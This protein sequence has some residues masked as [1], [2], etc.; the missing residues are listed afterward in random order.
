MKSIEVGQDV[1][2][3]APLGS[4][5]KAIVQDVGGA[6]L[7]LELFSGMRDPMERL[8]GERVAVQF[9]SRR[10]ICRIQGDARRSRLGAT[11]MQFHAVGKSVLIQR[12]DYVRIDA[13][14]PVTYQPIGM[15]GWTVETNTLNVS[16]GGF[17]LP[18][19]EGVRLGQ[20]LRF[21][22]ELSEDDQPLEVTAKAVR[23]TAGGA[24][25]F[26]ITGI[27][28]H[29]RDRLMHWVFARERLARQI[30]RDG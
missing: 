24:L 23:E 30:T 10:G 11:A 13:V 29:E 22:I 9:A 4:P 7:D 21:T 27:D 20:E 8:D 17:L 18:E 12:R 14:V 6:T 26:Q 25:G 19:P 2:V 28:K 3:I 1:Y 5:I 16:A 15:G